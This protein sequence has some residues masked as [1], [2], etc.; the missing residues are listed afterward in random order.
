MVFAVR[1]GPSIR[2][3]ARRYC[4]GVATIHLWVRRAGD[5]LSEINWTNR[6]SLSHKIQ[7]T[8]RRIEDV[9][10]T[11]RRE[12]KQTSVLRE[13]G[14]PAIHRELSRGIRPVPSVRTIGRIRLARCFG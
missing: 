1:Q 6:P 5:P 4:C 14:V 11:I 13:Y 7:R 9:V 2:E 12:L 3:V 10:L 8:D